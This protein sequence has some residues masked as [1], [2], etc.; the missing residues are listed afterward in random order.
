MK[1]L[2]YS[3]KPVKCVTAGKYKAVVEILDIVI[4]CIVRGYQV[5]EGGY[6]FQQNLTYRDFEL[7]SLN[8]EK[9]DQFHAVKFHMHKKY[10]KKLILL[11]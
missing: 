9:V 10:A 5:L 3:N 1:F 8:R 6:A 11:K 2:I 7:S 4:K